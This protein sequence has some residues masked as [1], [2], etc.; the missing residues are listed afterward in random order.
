MKKN[1]STLF[2]KI[3]GA[4]NDCLVFHSRGLSEE[5]QRNTAAKKQWIKTFSHRH[6]GLGSDQILEILSLKPLAIQIWNC[7]GS[8]AEMCGN[9]ARAFASLALQEG[10]ISSTDDELPLQISG[11]QYSLKKVAHGFALSLGAPLV[12]EERLL[13]LQKHRIPFTAVD[14]GNPHAVVFMAGARSWKAPN[15]FTFREYGVRIERHTALP[16]KT[17]VEFVRKIV[18]GAASVKL[19]VEV[20]ER[21]AG[22]T[23]SCGSGAVAVAAAYC[24]RSKKPASRYDIVMND[25][26]LSVRFERGS[27][28]LSGPSEIVAQGEYFY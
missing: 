4:G 3:H 28:Y 15:D 10:W 18:R 14:V 2:Y 26:V 11:K 23:L 27:A 7:D 24:A 1:Q 8:K 6:L 19:F 17:N 21:G 13:K 16:Q 12:S 9:G 5:L 22:A 25:Y 20:W